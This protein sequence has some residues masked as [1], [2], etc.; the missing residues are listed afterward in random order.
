MRSSSVASGRETRT[1]KA[2]AASS[3]SL[4]RACAAG[5]FPVGL[6]LGVTL[7]GFAEVVD[8]VLV[9]QFVVC[10][11]TFFDVEGGTTGQHTGQDQ[12]P[13]EERQRLDSKHG[14]TLRSNGVNAWP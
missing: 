3:F 6:G 4:I 11:L 1:E 9:P 7:D 8:G 12:H 2:A 13:G 10:G 5:Q 14:V